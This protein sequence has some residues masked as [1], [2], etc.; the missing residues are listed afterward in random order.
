MTQRSAP[1][2]QHFFDWA[3]LQEGRLKIDLTGKRRSEGGY[4]TVTAVWPT[5][6]APSAENTFLVD[7][8][9]FQAR[10]YR[11]AV[12]EAQ[13]HRID[14]PALHR[15]FI[16]HE[17]HDHV[18]YVPGGE[19]ARFVSADITLVQRQPGLA[20]VGMP[21]HSRDL[22]VLIFRSPPHGEV[23]IVGDAVLEEDWL[24][25]WAYYWPNG[26]S[27]A[28]IVQTWHS[29]MLILASADLIIP[30]HGPAIRITPDLLDAMVRSFPKA[31][32]AHACPE[33]PRRCGRASTKCERTAHEQRITRP[34][35]RDRESDRR[36]DDGDLRPGPRAGIYRS[37]IGHRILAYD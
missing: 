33:V 8:C 5:G 25:A 37:G 3:I 15:V 23:W 13:Q 7:P 19:P 36:P 16:T 6:E 29:I 17:H 32:Y 22:R 4:C 20:I 31:E 26:Y 12:E 30:G 14:L 10:L 28:E 9:F 27:A 18:P 34:S 11:Q 24:A 2:T 1:G 21:G 35:L